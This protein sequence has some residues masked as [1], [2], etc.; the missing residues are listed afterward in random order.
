[1]QRIGLN[2]K[3]LIHH[4]NIIS[5]SVSF[6]KFKD[7]VFSPQVSTPEIYHVI[8]RPISKAAMHGY[9]GTV[10]MYGQTTSGKTYTMLGTPESPGILPCTVR[11]IFSLSKND[12]THEYKVWVSYLEIYNENINDLLVPGSS[13]L[14]LKED[15]TFGVSV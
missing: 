13:N 14:K 2:E 8:A 10:F 6:L 15:P 4:N 1:M 7:N 3:Q 12:P 11:D 5:I 9:N